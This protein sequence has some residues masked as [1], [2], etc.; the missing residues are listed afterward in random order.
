MKN[1]L[2]LRW[3]H[4]LISWLLCLFSGFIISIILIGATGEGGEVGL[5]GILVTII[6]AAVSSPFIIIFCL[7]IHFWVLKKDRSKG[8]I[9]GLVFLLHALGSIMVFF[10]IVLFAEDVSNEFRRKGVRSNAGSERCTWSTQSES[11][12]GPTR[13]RVK[14]SS[15][16]RSRQTGQNPPGALPGMVA[17]QVGQI[18]GFIACAMD[19]AAPSIAEVI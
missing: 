14:A 15:A 4:F 19:G 9:H 13:V 16:S 5:M 8:E 3:Y 6:A 10:G 18:F 11:R 12:N 1:Q 17:L 7:L 2:Q